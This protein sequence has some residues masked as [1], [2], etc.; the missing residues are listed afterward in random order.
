MKTKTE[1]YLEWVEKRN[2]A[3][4]NKEVKGKMKPKPINRKMV[5]T[6]VY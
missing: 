2:T 3:L 5:T 4:R 6:P 1:L